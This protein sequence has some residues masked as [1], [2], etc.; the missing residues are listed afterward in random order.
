MLYTLRV[1]VFL[2]WP[3]LSLRRFWSARL[4]IG[5]FPAA[6]RE[7]DPRSQSRG[8]AATAHWAPLEVALRAQRSR[9]QALTPRIGEADP[10]ATPAAASLCRSALQ[11]PGPWS[12]T[13]VPPLFDSA[14][15]LSP[16]G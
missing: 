8:Q 4:L 1:Q 16:F 5:S 9:S 11:L 2:A 13:A 10:T 7:V 6:P 3:F 14:G 12:L 15:C